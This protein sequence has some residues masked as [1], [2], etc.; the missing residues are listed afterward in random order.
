VT[1]APDERD[2]IRAAMERIINGTPQHSNGALTIVALAHEAQLPRSALTQRHHDL[3]TEFYAKAKAKAATATDEQRLRETIAKLRSTIAN[4]NKELD[5][6]REDVPA[7]V[8][9]VNVL[10]AENTRL[11]EELAGRPM[12]TLQ[13]GKVIRFPS[14]AAP[15]AEQP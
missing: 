9:V 11:R 7:L 14:R 3:R 1:P 6:I 12:T 4:K 10:T 13:D 8:R 2:R 15:A 5:R